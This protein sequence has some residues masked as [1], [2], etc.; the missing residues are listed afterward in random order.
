MSQALIN[1][2]IGIV[3]TLLGGCAGSSG[4]DYTS[5]QDA[6][7]LAP[8]KARITVVRNGSLMY[9]AVDARLDINGERMAALGRG[10]G[11]TGNF[12]PG[13]TV[14]TT[15][16]WSA[17]GRFTIS[18]ETKPNHDY[19]FEISPRGDGA[20]TGMLFGVAGMAAEASVSEQ[21]GPFQIVPISAE[22]K[23]ARA[24]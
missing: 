1:A 22:K 10:E 21:S 12:R 9:L 15:E 3:L 24:K 4:V 23:G 8:G 7:P 20:A 13:K 17:P 14:L 5:R 6:V 11:Y 16:A 19:V 18:V 2:V